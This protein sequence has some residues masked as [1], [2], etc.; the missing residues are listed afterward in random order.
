MAKMTCTM[1]C[2][3]DL[4]Q[5]TYNI[6][7]ISGHESPITEYYCEGCGWDAVYHVTHG[8][9]STRYNPKEENFN[10]VEEEGEG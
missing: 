4:L 9:L 3:S 5:R 8:I 7:I 10:T 2:D 1:G 6:V